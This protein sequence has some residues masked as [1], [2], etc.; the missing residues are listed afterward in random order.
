LMG[1]QPTVQQVI[2]AACSFGQDDDIT[3]LSVTRVAGLGLHTAKL[4]LVTQIAAGSAG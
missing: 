4:N 1:A 2:D 3:V